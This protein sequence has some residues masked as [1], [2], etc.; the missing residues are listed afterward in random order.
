MI[1]QVEVLGQKVR[2]EIKV[3]TSYRQE[4]QD[5]FEM[6]YWDWND[7]LQNQWQCEVSIIEFVILRLNCF[8]CT[9]AKEMTLCMAKESH[10]QRPHIEQ[11]WLQLY[12]LLAYAT[13]NYCTYHT[14]S[15][16]DFTEVPLRSDPEPRLLILAGR[17]GGTR[18]ID[19]WAGPPLASQRWA[20]E[21]NEEFLCLLMPRDFNKLV[22]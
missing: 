22:P 18:N 20:K 2:K 3:T 13:E 14:R 16:Q 12:H 17:P 19:T 9:I 1:Y 10:A 15:P 11:L 5:E 7:W 4:K 6:S 21:W 8:S